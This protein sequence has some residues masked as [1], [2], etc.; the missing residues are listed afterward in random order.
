[1]AL[2]FALCASF[3]FAQT[4]NGMAHKMSRNAAVLSSE[5]VEK[6]V[7]GFNASIFTKAAGDTLKVWDFAAGKTD[8]ST[9]VVTNGN[10]D[11]ITFHLA[12]GTTVNQ[13]CHTNTNYYSQWHRLSSPSD[14]A[15][16][17]QANYPW[18]ST[19]NASWRQ[20][21]GFTRLEYYC[22]TARCHAS[23]LN[24]LMFNSMMEFGANETTPVNS[25][26]DLGTVSTTGAAIL[27]VRFFQYYNNYYDE[28]Y[29]DFSFDGDQTWYTMGINVDGVDVAINS[30]IWAWSTYTLPTMAA[31]K[32]NLHLRIR[33]YSFH[34]GSAHGYWWALDDVMLIEG[35]ADR[36]NRWNAQYSEGAYQT[37][38][39][40]LDLPLL[41]YA[42]VANNGVNAQTAVASK[43]YSYNPTT[44]ESNLIISQNHGD[45]AA[46]PTV[47]HVNVIDPAGWVTD[48]D[49]EYWGWYN[50]AAHRAGVTGKGLPTANAGV[51]Y[52]YSTI[53]S[54]H[55]GEQSYD[56]IAYRVNVADN[57]ERIWGYD[58]GI[59]TKYSFFGYGKTADGQYLTDTGNFANAGYRATARYT[60][61]AVVPENWVLRGI[62][63]VVTTEEGKV[64]AHAQIA[65]VAFRDEYTEEGVTFVSL[66]TGAGNYEVMASDF[67]SNSADL[68]STEYLMPGEYSTIRIMFPEQPELQPYTSYRLGYQM[69][70]AAQFAT[71]R[72][73]NRYYTRTEDGTADSVVYFYNDPQMAK[74]STFFS[75]NQGLAAPQHYSALCYDGAWTWGQNMDGMPMIRAIVGPRQD[76]PT[77]NVNFTCT[78][79][80]DAGE[81]LGYVTDVE[82]END[83]CNGTATVTEHAY[84]TFFILPSDG[85]I[86]DAEALTIDG[87]HVADGDNTNTYEVIHYLGTNDGGQDY[88]YWAIEFKDVTADHTVAVAY[89]EGNEV[90][91]DAVEN[92]RMKLQPNP[93]T[94]QV[95]LSL[96]GVTGMVNCALIDMSG[97]VVFSQEMNAENEQTI[98]LTNVAKGAYFVRINNAQ[99]NKIEKLIVR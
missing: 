94:S 15:L 69:V 72:T 48:D 79:N 78:G 54:T 74:W 37:M 42:K 43:I 47:T 67:A 19:N 27:D 49:A 64:E 55:F 23:T 28:C 5:Q 6:P 34:R 85:I 20:A 60:T 24:G 3:A 8:Y 45:F 70:E 18:W 46:D 59:L 66:N 77:H 98:D 41:W 53:S 22:D 29:I 11:S 51:N 35:A 36:W 89:K 39:Q 86:V 4:Q 63:M 30:Q 73:N 99:F 87:T 93:A 76:L 9:G 81:T 58:N 80:E 25:F 83:Y 57:G 92:V 16:D 82:E 33:Y 71:A 40:G 7:V 88:N 65:P 62:E 50:D 2:S 91:I 97:R 96:N 21:N 31:N 10:R 17:N 14:P 38:P 1:M 44:D 95:R 90:G 12:D 52:V 84:S 56:T 75:T 26:I 68:Q 32:A 13:P 61:G